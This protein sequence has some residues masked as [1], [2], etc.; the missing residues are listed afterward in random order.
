M[1]KKKAWSQTKMYEGAKPPVKKGVVGPEP[2]PTPRYRSK[3]GG[4]SG[5]G[6]GRGFGSGH[7]G[8]LRKGPHPHAPKNG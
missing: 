5:T 2:S 7:E 8:K 1:A 6:M 3:V 4:V